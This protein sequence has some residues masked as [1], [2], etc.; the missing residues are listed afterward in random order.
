[1]DNVSETIIEFANPLVCI[2]A[3]GVDYGMILTA[4][5][6]TGNLL[7]NNYDPEG[8]WFTVVSTKMMCLQQLCSE[9]SLK[10]CRA[11]DHQY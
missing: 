9:A 3:Y 10:Q 5:P 8:S 11:C 2:L 1:M 7:H 4:W 6:V